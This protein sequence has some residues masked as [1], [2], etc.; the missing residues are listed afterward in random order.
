MRGRTLKFMEC[1][2]HAMRARKELKTLLKELTEVGADPQTYFGSDFH[3]CLR[4]NLLAL[5]ETIDLANAVLDDRDINVDEELFAIKQREQ[6]GEYCLQC[7]EL[8]QGE[9]GEYLCSCVT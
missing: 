2:G 4:R 5:N 6:Y 3:E 8:W 7:Y 1:D 9:E